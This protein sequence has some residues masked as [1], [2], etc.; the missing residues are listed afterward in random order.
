MAVRHRFLAGLSTAAALLAVQVGPA[1]A[2]GEALWSL[3]RSLQ[4]CIETGQATP[5]RQAETQVAALVRNPAYLRSSHLC[6]EE[7]YELGQVVALLPM[8]DAI[9]AEVMATAADVQQACQPYGF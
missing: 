6:K 4:A 2:G 5:C 9:P 8:R 1:A 7:I 3:Q